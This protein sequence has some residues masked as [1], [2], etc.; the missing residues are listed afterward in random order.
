MI[1]EPEQV[2]RLR[3]RSL[4]DLDIIPTFDLIRPL[5]VHLGNGIVSLF[6]SLQAACKWYR[7]FELFVFQLVNIIGRAIFERSFHLFDCLNDSV[8]FLGELAFLT[9]KGQLESIRA[10]TC[11]VAYAVTRRN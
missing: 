9:K 3:Q 1:R 2:L 8:R 4:L 5:P 6:Q 7:D 10:K 11:D